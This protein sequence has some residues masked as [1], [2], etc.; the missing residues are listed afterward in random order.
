MRMHPGLFV[1]FISFLV[2]LC[3]CAGMVTRGTNSYGGNDAFQKGNQS[4]PA[5]DMNSLQTAG[6]SNNSEAVSFHQNHQNKGQ[7]KDSVLVQ[8]V[9][10]MVI[11]Y[12][13]ATLITE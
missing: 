5:N 2:I 11:G 4:V 8:F 1:F 13:I 6:P 12:V 9:C 10:W 7:A 3:G